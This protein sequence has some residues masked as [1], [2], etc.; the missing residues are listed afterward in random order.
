MLKDMP[1]FIK[2]LFFTL[3]LCTIAISNSAQNYDNTKVGDFKLPEILVCQ[4][5]KKIKTTEAWEN[6]RRPEIVKLFEDNVYGKVPSDFDEINFIVQNE[7]KSALNGKAILKEVA[8]KVFRNKKNITINLKLFSPQGQKKS[9]PVFLLINHRGLKTMD[10]SRQIRDDFWPV[11][12]IIDAGFAIAGFDVQ[13]IAPD[14]KIRFQNGVLDQLYPEQL[15]MGNGMGT[16]GVW[17]WGASRAIDYFENENCVDASKVILVGH[18][19]GGKAALWCGAQDQR[20][21]LTIVDTPE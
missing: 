13:D 6:I 18:S 4:N 8:I 16:L 15:N 21:A 7:D 3:L 2:L 1:S 11:E 9:V 17:A 14:D 19:R 12:Q 20:I 10:V 5:N